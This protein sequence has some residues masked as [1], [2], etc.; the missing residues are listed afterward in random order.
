MADVTF[1]SGGWVSL[2]A[3]NGTYQQTERNLKLD[4]NVEVHHDSGYE[5]KTEKMDIDVTGQTINSDTPITGHGPAAD[6]SASGLEANGNNDTLIF[7]GP[8]KLILRKS[9]GTEDMKPSEQKPEKDK[10]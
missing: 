4:G 1:K 2:K 9:S 5:L 10:K 3:S 7:K 8:A 6:I